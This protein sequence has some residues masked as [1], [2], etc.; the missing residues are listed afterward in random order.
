MEIVIASDKKVTIKT[1]M[2]IASGKNVVLTQPYNPKNVV[3]ITHTDKTLVYRFYPSPETMSPAD[4]FAYQ[5]MTNAY[6][7]ARR[8]RRVHGA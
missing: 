2:V 8:G 1:G 4:K 3:F 5:S 7:F 6:R